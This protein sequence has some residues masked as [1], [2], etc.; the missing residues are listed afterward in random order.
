MQ[1]RFATELSSAQY[2][3]EQAWRQASLEHCPRHPHGGCGF[4]R[5]GTY[6][7]TTPPGT[8][9]A[10]W[11]CPQ[12]HCTFSLLPDAFAA[13]FPGTLV[14]IERVVATVERARSLEAAADQL[15]PDS[16]SLPNAIRWT[17]R[18]VRLVHTL[19]T[20]LVG[21]LPAVFLGCA[22][23]VWAVRDRLGTDAA[24]VGLRTLAAAYLPVLAH[25]LGFQAPP[26]DTGGHKA[27]RQHDIG[28]DPP[29]PP[30]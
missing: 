14:D 18:R 19:L 28:P 26:R 24:L 20:V 10:R 17:R 21:L 22:P 5:H 27:N 30:R 23:T 2:V 7:R 25:P 3:T 13:R 6:Q 12:S 4:A 9:I 16:V 29:V 8:R 1:L 11:Y 15:R